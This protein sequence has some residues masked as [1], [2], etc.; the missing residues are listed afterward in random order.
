VG[1]NGWVLSQKINISAV[2]IAIEDAINKAVAV[3]F[4]ADSRG[5]DR[6]FFGKIFILGV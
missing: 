5:A 6:V 1:V 3:D 2:F 4:S